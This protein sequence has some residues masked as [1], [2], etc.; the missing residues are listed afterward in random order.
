VYLDEQWV[1]SVNELA[2]CDKHL[3][4]DSVKMQYAL[5]NV[6][7]QQ[8]IFLDTLHLLQKA[9]LSSHKRLNEPIWFAI[10]VLQSQCQ[11]RHL[12]SF[13]SQLFPLANNVYEAMDHLR[14]TLH[15][16]VQKQCHLKQQYQHRNRHPIFFLSLFTTVDEHNDADFLN[17]EANQCLLQKMAPAMTHLMDQWSLFETALYECYVQNVFGKYHK[18]HLLH[19]QAITPTMPTDTLFGDAL[20]RL[21]PLTL[22]RAMQRSLLDVSHIQTLDPMAFVALPRLAV[23]AGMTWLAHLTGWRYQNHQQKKLPVWMMGHEKTMRDTS[24]ALDQLEL[25]LLKTKSEDAHHAFVKTYQDLE[26][27]LVYGCDEQ[28]QDTK[29][30][31]LAICSVA[32]AVLSSH[33]AQSF[34]VVLYHLFKHVGLQYDIEFEDEQDAVPLEQTILDLAI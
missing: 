1:S 9:V 15:R 23:L 32:D 17:S 33:R 18:D 30:I 6:H 24:T 2:F 11:I 34:T 26:F 5:D 3:Q 7:R 20:T 13:T 10:Q 12:E 21:L 8:R 4:V 19:H 28:M 14:S 29:D 31:Y 25:Q 22:D 27:A 16:L